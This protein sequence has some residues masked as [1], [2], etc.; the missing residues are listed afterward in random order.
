[1]LPKAELQSQLDQHES[2]LKEETTKL[3]NLCWVAELHRKITEDAEHRLN[4]RN[5]VVCALN[6]AIRYNNEKAEK[7]STYEFATTR[8]TS[9][10]NNF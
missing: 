10:T 1:M 4:V 6:Y 7:V 9:S 5:D 2:L 8:D 3:E